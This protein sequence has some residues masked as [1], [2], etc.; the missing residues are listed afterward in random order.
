MDNTLHKTKE[1]L[2]SWRLEIWHAKSQRPQYIHEKFYINAAISSFSSAVSMKFCA[3]M[4]IFEEDFC[5]K[6]DISRSPYDRVRCLKWPF[7]AIL[8]PKLFF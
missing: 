8:V 2:V 5:A 1:F 4:L 7:S 6:F 3:V